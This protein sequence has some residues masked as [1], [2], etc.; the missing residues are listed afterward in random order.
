MKTDEGFS[1]T[2][3]AFEQEEIKRIREKYIEKEKSVSKLD[4]IKK[5]DK[6]V[7]DTATF[8]AILLG[9][10]GSLVLGTGMSMVMVWG[11]NLFVPGIFVG[12]LGIAMIAAAYP[13]FNIVVSYK[14]KKIA[15]E[16]LRLTDELID[17]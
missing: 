11:S 1:Y 9:V 5:L 12:V 8:V 4:I 7:T 6:S 17:Q 3:S 15:P 2:Y 16:I 13:V 10:L 14:R